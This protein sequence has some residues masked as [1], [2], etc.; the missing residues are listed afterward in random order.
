MPEKRSYDAFELVSYERGGSEASEAE[1]EFPSNQFDIPA[2]D[3][4]AFELISPASD[5]IY[6]CHWTWSDEQ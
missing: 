4:V 2:G 3:L 6:E 5:R 1:A